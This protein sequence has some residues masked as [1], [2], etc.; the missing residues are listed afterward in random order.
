MIVNCDLSLRGEEGVCMCV[1]VFN[2]VKILSRTVRGGFSVKVTIE[3]LYPWWDKE[4]HANIQENKVLDQEFW[5]KKQPGKPEWRRR[6]GK[7][8]S[9]VWSHRNN[10]RVRLW[11]RS[12]KIWFFLMLTMAAL[13]RISLMGKWRWKRL[14]NKVSSITVIIQKKKMTRVTWLSNITMW[15]Y[16]GADAFQP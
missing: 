13:L 2:S 5:V 8:N 4:G 16:H 14:A 15:I 6:H 11:V 7:V 3:Q 10:L 9:M 12:H 1:C